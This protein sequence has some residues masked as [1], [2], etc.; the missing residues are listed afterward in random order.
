[1]WGIM[2]LKASEGER[3]DIECGKRTF[4]GSSVNRGMIVSRMINRKN[5]TL[6]GS[7]RECRRRIFERFP[8]ERFDVLLR[9]LFVLASRGIMRIDQYGQR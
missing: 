3:E 4:E 6:D 8:E 5:L 2:G 1:M 9:L 7:P